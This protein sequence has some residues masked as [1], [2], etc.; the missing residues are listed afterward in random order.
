MVP[1]DNDS[2]CSASFTSFL[3]LR[4]STFANWLLWV[5]YR[6]WTTTTAGNSA[7]SPPK[8]SVSA[9]N[10]PADAPMATS[11]HHRRRSLLGCLALF[12][13]SPTASNCNHLR[14]TALKIVAHE[15]IGPTMPL[16]CFFDASAKNESG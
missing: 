10:P 15:P 12:V 1:R 8:T 7:P 16:S 6:C 9:D 3:V 4:A 2:P 14:A 11:S 5:G 13:T